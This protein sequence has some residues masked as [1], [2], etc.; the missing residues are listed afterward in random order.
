MIDRRL[1]IA[2]ALATPVFGRAGDDAPLKLRDLYEKDMSFSPAA[3]ALEGRRIRVLGYMAPPLKAEARFFVQTLRPMAVCPFCDSE[4]EWPAD[5]LVVY[6]KRI[7]EVQPFNA[8]IETR[9]VL[10]LGPRT[11]PETGFVSRVRLI[12]A[13][14]AR[15]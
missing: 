9:G 5:I 11:D 14:I 8:A 2:G 6:T 4:A 7:V 13:E 15:V 12:D 10:E 3:Q 1:V